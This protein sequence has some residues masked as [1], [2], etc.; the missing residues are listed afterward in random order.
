MRQMSELSHYQVPNIIILGSN[1]RST[2]CRRIR[3][4]TSVCNMFKCDK[5]LNPLSRVVSEK[6]IFSQLVNKSL[7]FDLTRRFTT[8]FTKSRSPVSVLSQMSPVHPLSQYFKFILILSSHLLR[9]GLP[10]GLSPSGC[11]VSTFHLYLWELQ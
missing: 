7:F 8:V 5:H 10:S 9:L 11:P 4:K 6:L 2:I 3:P 1:F